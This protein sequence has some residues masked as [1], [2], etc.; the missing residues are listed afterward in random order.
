[1]ARRPRSATPVPT[2]PSVSS[3][4]SDVPL[5]DECEAA[6]GR[7]TESIGFKSAP[8]LTAFLR[9]IVDAAL[10][11]RSDSIKAYTVAVGALG[12]PPDFDPVGDASVRVEA[13]RLRLA[14]GRYYEGADDPIL[15]TMPRG[16]YVPAFRRRDAA[17]PPREQAMSQ[18]VEGMP[19]LSA[20][21]ERNAEPRRQHRRQHEALT[22][23]IATLKVILASF[24]AT[25]TDISD[26]TRQTG[27][28][29]RG[30]AS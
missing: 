13:G 18:L 17:G 3:D 11:G 22:R 2:P 24:G 25:V 7:V 30:H 15:I 19:E 16:G 14:L 12:R 26:A 23:N 10:S 21:R 4:R 20:A 1:M 28:R 5:R 29:R 27:K 9:F 8:R 6:L